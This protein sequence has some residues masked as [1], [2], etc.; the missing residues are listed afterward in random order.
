MPD[1]TW[2]TLKEAAEVLK[3][4]TITVTNYIK[5][6][7]LKAKQLPGGQYRIAQSEVERLLAV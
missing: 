7:Q 5:D 4:S 2:L 3:L 1:E 6:G